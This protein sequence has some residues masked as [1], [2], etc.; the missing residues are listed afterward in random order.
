[1]AEWQLLIFILSNLGG[2]D[3]VKF[4]V[5]DISEEDL[6][7]KLDT[8]W[9]VYD[10]TSTYSDVFTLNECDVFFKDSN[11]L[12]YNILLYFIYVHF[13]RSVWRFP[14]G[15]HELREL[16]DGYYPQSY[17]ILPFDSKH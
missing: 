2:V 6:L 9:Q 7:F 4:N 1:M 13:H 15:H 10:F 12:E 11:L 14:D 8:V 16:N 3:M 5:P 17:L